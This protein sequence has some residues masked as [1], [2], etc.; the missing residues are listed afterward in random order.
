MI[1]LWPDEVTRN[2]RNLCNKK[3]EML[4]KSHGNQKKTQFDM[5]LWHRFS[6]GAA[7]L[8]RKTLIRSTIR[9]TICFIFGVPLFIAQNWLTAEISFDLQLMSCFGFSE[10]NWKDWHTKRERKRKKKVKK[11]FLL[12]YTEKNIQTHSRR[13]SEPCEWNKVITQSIFNII[14]AAHPH[15]CFS[16]NGAFFLQHVKNEMKS[17][18]KKLIKNSFADFR[19]IHQRVC[20]VRPPTTIS[21]YGMLWF[22]VRMIRLSRME[23]SN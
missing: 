21:W 4:F 13:V 6:L 1:H 11:L 15:H 23:R 18:N 22:S 12:T 9:S 20:R 10:Q 14:A 16:L 7:M 5:N 19:R 17:E 3:T 2:L 8:V